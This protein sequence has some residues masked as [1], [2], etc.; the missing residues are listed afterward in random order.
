M[1]MHP[2]IDEADIKANGKLLA[3]EQIAEIAKIER[4]LAEIREQIQPIEAQKQEQEALRE[5]VINKITIFNDPREVINRRIFDIFQSFI[6]RDKQV[7]AFK[8][9]LITNLNEFA[10]HYDSME[11]ASYI[12]DLTDA[13]QQAEGTEIYDINDLLVG[14]SIDDIFD[15]HVVDFPIRSVIEQLEAVEM[16]YEAKIG[17]F[18]L[19][20]EAINKSVQTHSA[21][22]GWGL[23]YDENYQLT[24]LSRKTN[25]AFD[26][27]VIMITQPETGTTAP[28]ALYRGK[29][30]MLGE[31][32][33]GAVKLCQNLETGEWCA[34]KIQGSIM[35]QPTQAEN[36]VLDRF[37]M[38][39]G[40]L[41]RDRKYYSA[42]TL[43]PGNNLQQYLTTLGDADALEL[44]L[45]LTQQALNL[46][47][48]FHQ[49]Y[50]HRDIKL[51]N[52]VYDP[53]KKQLYLCDFG[54]AAELDAEGNYHDLSGSGTILAPEVDE[55]H[56][57]RVDY[58]VKSDIYS[59]GKTIEELFEGCESPAVISEIVESMT[60]DNPTMRASNLQ[61]IADTVKAELSTVH[62]AAPSAP[63]S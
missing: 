28:F 45:E 52:F 39:K 49:H 63:S 40:E 24:K 44:R 20:L 5:Q 33:F 19:Q 46:V 37:E 16:A 23:E 41:L 13:I 58:T 57:G 2:K 18:E 56:A 60:Q 15:S 14:E 1:P 21:D 59:L 61:T 10:S 7:E 31:G 43:L 4:Y 3:D 48:D 55:S 6:N 53:V 9:A 22:Q 34:I 47:K 38:F 30:R 51:E 29:D 35:K 42:Q 12:N 17:E 27:S 32:G 62:H 25:A 8:R 50:I 11:M 36:A 26:F 54:M